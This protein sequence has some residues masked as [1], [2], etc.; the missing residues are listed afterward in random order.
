MEV[1]IDICDMSDSLK[2]EVEKE[3]TF[4]GHL[5]I[6]IFIRQ[7]FRIERSLLTERLFLCFA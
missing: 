5:M 4:R 3:A 2:E 7:K 6:T 1:S